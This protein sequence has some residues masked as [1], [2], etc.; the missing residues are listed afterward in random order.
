MAEPLEYILY[1]MAQ[2]YIKPICGSYGWM[3]KVFISRKN[4]QRRM[5][6]SSCLCRW[7]TLAYPADPHQGNH[8]CI[9][10]QCS[11]LHISTWSVKWLC[12]GAS[13]TGCWSP[14]V[15]WHVLHL[16]THGWKTCCGGFHVHIG[17]AYSVM[18]DHTVWS[19]CQNHS[20]K[21]KLVSSFI[22]HL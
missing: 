16:L 8:D 13:L 6:K 22:Q 15:W 20:G 18:Q 19:Y 11:T 21:C 7:Q 12:S 14:G 1:V 10:R 2:H 5:Y 9:L 4:S 17:N 3:L